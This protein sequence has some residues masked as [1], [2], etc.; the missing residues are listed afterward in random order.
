MANTNR[1]QSSNREHFLGENITVLITQRHLFAYAYQFIGINFEPLFLPLLHS[2]TLAACSL[3]TFLLVAFAC[4]SQISRVRVCLCVYIQLPLF[5][6]PTNNNNF[7][8]DFS[9]FPQ[10][11]TY[12]LYL[13]YRTIYIANSMAEKKRL[14]L[15]LTAFQMPSVR[16]DGACTVH[17]AANI[18]LPMIERER[19][20]EKTHKSRWYEAAQ[21]NTAHLSY[22][23]LYYLHMWHT[24][25]H[26]SA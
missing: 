18:I 10:I 26:S 3:F 17:I 8:L 16:L 5:L 11:H 15:I 25:T 7:L 23:Y 1:M 2:S 4:S 14:Y 19:G 24:H 6:R 22:T 20:T 9:A 13:I 21:H 12:G